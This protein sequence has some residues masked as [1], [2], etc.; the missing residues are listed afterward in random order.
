MSDFPISISISARPTGRLLT[1]TGA[2]G[3][4]REPAPL[5]QAIVSVTIPTDDMAR[6]TRQF[7][8]PAEPAADCYDGKKANE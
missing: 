5:N 2:S 6:L 3:Y 4:S 7:S 1:T 8:R